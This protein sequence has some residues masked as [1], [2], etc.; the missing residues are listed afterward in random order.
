MKRWLINFVVISAVLLATTSSAFG[1]SATSMVAGGQTGNLRVGNLYTGATE[2]E[3]NLNNQPIGRG[4]KNVIVNIDSDGN[5]VFEKTITSDSNLV[6]VEFDA[7]MAIT[8]LMPVS[9]ETVQDGITLTSD[10]NDADGISAVF[11]SIREPNAGS[12]VPIGQEDLAATFNAATGEWELNFDT[13]DLQDGYYVVLAKGVDTYG[14]VGWSEVVP[15]SIR[16]WVIIT[17]L[18][19][20]PNNKAG[21]T[22]PVKFT[23]RIASAVDPAMPFVYNDELEIRIYDKAKPSVIL[24]RSVFGRGSTNYRIDSKGKKYMTNFKT[25]KKPATYVVEIWQPANGFLVGSFTFA[26]TK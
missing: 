5:K 21:R 11:F 15:F 17:M 10:A 26:T 14:N 19:S 16:N 24:Q 4:G 6:P 9:D 22:M 18:P 1:G 2:V 12:G 25:S 20:T 3:K 13:T 8:V 23:L 7:P